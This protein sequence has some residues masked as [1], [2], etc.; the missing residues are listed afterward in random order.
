MIHV[1]YRC[2]LDSEAQDY[3]DKKRKWVQEEE[4]NLENAEDLFREWLG[5]PA[6]SQRP[7]FG[8]Y[9]G[10]ARY[11]NWDQMNINDKE[12]DIGQYAARRYV[13]NELGPKGPLGMPVWRPAPNND[14]IHH[15]GPAVPYR[16]HVA[17]LHTN[18]ATQSPLASSPSLPSSPDIAPQIPSVQDVGIREHLRL[19]QDLQDGRFTAA[20]S[21]ATLG[22][23]KPDRTESAASQSGEDELS[24]THDSSDP[25]MGRD[26]GVMSAPDKDDEGEVDTRH[27]LNPGDVIGFRTK[28][29]AMLAIFIR[30]FDTQ[31]QFYSMQGKWFHMGSRFVSF[32][33]PN[34]FSQQDLDPIIEH[35]PDKEVD[36][37]ELET[38][39]SMTIDVPQGIGAPLLEK[40]QAL[41]NDS[42]E[43]YREHAG[44]LDRAHILLARQRKSTEM[45]LPEIAM[46]LLQKQNASELTDVMLWT[47]EKTLDRNTTFRKNRSFHHRGYPLW[48]IHP[49]AMMEGHE[50]VRVWVREYLEGVIAKVTSLNGPSSVSEHG[51]DSQSSNP[52]PRF[53]GKARTLVESS[54]AHRS[55][56]AHAG[57]G[58]MD[59][60]AMAGKSPGSAEG[61]A[62][63]LASFDASETKIIMYLMSW[64]VTWDVI[65]AGGTWSLS[66]AIL[67][68]TGL[69]EG[70]ALNERTG[71]LFLQELGVLAPWENRFAYEVKVLPALSNESKIEN[72]ATIGAP[73][74]ASHTRLEDSLEHLRKDWGNLPVY[75]IDDAS[76]QEIDDGISLERL[77]GDDSLIWVHVH[78]ANPSAFIKPSGAVARYAAQLL[79]TIYLPDKTYPL[80]HPK[81]SQAHFSLAKD[82]PVLTLSAKLT[83]DGD[84]IE[85]DI[86]PGWIRNVKRLT[87]ARLSR[88][89]GEDE[90]T[91]ER[92]SRLLR[93]GR[94]MSFT[95]AESAE[96]DLSPSESADLR[97]LQQLGAARRQ[98]RTGG[99]SATR[100]FH[101]TVPEPQVFLEKGGIPRMFNPYVGRQFFGDPSISWEALE[102][103]MTGELRRNESRVAVADI[104]VLAGEIASRWCGERNVPAIYRG[105]VRDPAPN[106]SPE[107]YKTNVIDQAKQ[108]KGYVPIMLYRVYNRLLGQSTCRSFPFPHAILGTQSYM[109]ATSPLRRYP[110]MLVHWQIQAA[111]LHEARHGKGSLLV[112]NNGN[113]GNSTSDNAP[114]ASHL[115]FSRADLD[116]MIPGLELRE[117]AITEIGKK[118][119]THWI[120]Q[121]LHRAFH[122]HEATLPP[123]FDV[124]VHHETGVLGVVFNA[125]G[126][127]KQ[128]SGINADVLEN[129]VSRRAGGIRVGDWW[130][131][132]IEGV[133]TYASR[134]RMLPVR[135]TQR[136]AFGLT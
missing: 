85:T 42:A 38:L 114:S 109:K 102:V 111:L 20:P 129:E 8:Q 119:A 11:E 32:R 12:L 131:T 83:L 14:M 18:R 66:S 41:S 19:W 108:S 126:Y 24:V 103:D 34:V 37:K 25:A 79:Q 50:Q 2:L 59:A 26:L 17:R 51:E 68:A 53:L 23:P 76:A 13:A 84:I 15:G 9:R 106:M 117:R 80:L 91:S 133:D 54:R 97:T 58:P 27:F 31:S 115:P 98:K 78:V 61:Y 87:P 92:Q 101:G 48:K 72:A 82:R 89:L 93:V 43:V 40:L 62:K 60:G 113:N 81:L 73:F 46:V 57:L 132:R 105:T 67:R 16:S 52:I 47:V 3:L 33:M 100:S 135:L 30:N 74:P 29:E 70:H 75:C 65:S 6:A 136:D 112:G 56:T 95:P 121:L 22:F 77:P 39:Q 110:D 104:M 5:Q 128:L 28:A 123:L 69:Y 125:V 4:E 90:D 88:E 64:C 36:A 118:S 71:C 35:L 49:A 134:L 120:M 86:T 1:D 127:T 63:T 7:G 21:P 45:T 44:R 94:P 99:E 107:A 55:V 124:L 116:A 122:F 10:P 96:C 130:Q